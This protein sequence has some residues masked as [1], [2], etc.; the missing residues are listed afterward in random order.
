MGSTQ[1]ENKIDQG[2]VCI[3]IILLL[4]IFSFNRTTYFTCTLKSTSTECRT[5]CKQSPNEDE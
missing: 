3:G 1:G 5:P 2:E 4:F